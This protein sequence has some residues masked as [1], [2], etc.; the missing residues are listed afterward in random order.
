MWASGGQGARALTRAYQCGHVVGRKL[1]VGIWWA[2]RARPHEGLL[3]WA[4]GGQKAGYGHLV[5]R[6]CAPSRGLASVGRPWSSLVQNCEYSRFGRKFKITRNFVGMLCYFPAHLYI[7]CGVCTKK[8]QLGIRS[9]A[10]VFL[11]I[12][13][14]TMFRPKKQNRTKLRRNA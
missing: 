6:A 11:R 7:L 14:F 2:G 5:G 8:N 9:L 10:G 12:R 13:L 1:A 3:V 4:S